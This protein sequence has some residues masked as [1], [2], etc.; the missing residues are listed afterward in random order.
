MDFILHTFAYTPLSLPLR[1]HLPLQIKAGGY[2]NDEAQV[3][4]EVFIVVTSGSS[5]LQRLRTM[6]VTATSGRPRVGME[7]RERETEK[8]REGERGGRRCRCEDEGV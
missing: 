7:G 8:G 5:T 2:A 4:A 1:R 6:R 3:T